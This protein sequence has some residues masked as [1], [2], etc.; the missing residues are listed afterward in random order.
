LSGGLPYPEDL[1]AKSIPPT[2]KTESTGIIFF[3]NI[4]SRSFL[5]AMPK[6][7]GFSRPVLQALRPDPQR[8]C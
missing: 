8:F 3:E 6:N 4:I 2:R 1:K 5:K 7:N